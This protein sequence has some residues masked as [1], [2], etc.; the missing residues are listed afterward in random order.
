LICTDPDFTGLPGG[1]RGLL[2]RSLSGT[3][4]RWGRDSLGRVIDA[5]RDS[6]GR[7]GPN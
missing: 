1:D 6:A 7:L 4:R 2:G 3:A 5:V